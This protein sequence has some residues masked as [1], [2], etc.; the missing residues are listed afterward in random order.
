MYH[1]R[2]RFAWMLDSFFFSRC[3]ARAYLLAHDN[4]WTHPRIFCSQ[5]LEPSSVLDFLVRFTTVNVL[6]WSWQLSTDL[7]LPHGCS[8]LL[9][10]CLCEIKC[11]RSF[12]FACCP[13]FIY[14]LSL[15][16]NKSTSKVVLSQTFLGLTEFIKKRTSVYDTKFLF[17]LLDTSW[18]IIS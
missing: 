10:I 3:N 11:I 1:S 15:S 17:L 14:I 8:H 13:C 2:H 7:N 5:L 9:R 12:H 4:M 18:N 16:Q 6:I